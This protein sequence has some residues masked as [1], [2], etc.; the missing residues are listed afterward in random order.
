MRTLNEIRYRLFQLDG[1]KTVCK[2]GSL[3]FTNYLEEYLGLS[4]GYK[5]SDE[6]LDGLVEELARI[7]ALAESRGKQMLVLITPSKAGFI[8]KQI[9]DRFMKMERFYNE[10]DRAVHRLTARMEETGIPYLDSAPLLRGEQ[11]FDIFPKGG[12]HWTREASLQIVESMCK[13]LES[14][15]GIQ[16]KHVVVTGRRTQSVPWQ[17]SLIPDNDL[18]V[19]MNKFSSIK[20]QYSYPLEAEDI[21][22]N[23]TLPAVFVAGDSFSLAI[24]EILADHDMAK[25][26]NLLFYAQSLYDYDEAATTVE[27][28]FDPAI[29]QK[30][31]ESDII[32]LEV[33]EVNIT[34]MG[35]GFY[36]VLEEI[37]RKDVEPQKE[38]FQVQYR[39]FSPWETQNGV[40]HRWAYGKNA[41]LVYENVLPT[42]TLETTIWVPYDAYANL[43][44]FS[45]PVT[46]DAYVNGKKYQQFHCTENS[47]WKL[48]I[49]LKN[50]EV[51]Q[52]V[53]VE[54][55]SP[56]SFVGS[57]PTGEREICLQ[58]L[59]AG[60]DS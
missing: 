24:C 36:T 47:I 58:V 7:N 33:N 26:V 22:D 16:M 6:Y 34:Q 39:G 55:R 35:S 14:N 13:E 17:R 44:G 3:I 30:V 27:S 59:N 11:S 9:P 31:R 46:L 8:E 57:G 51:S 43:E 49:P 25:D 12:I 21:P 53:T 2:D 10:E 18:D 28:F 37:L 4:P 29:E 42:D 19:L 54:I 60:R 56:Y 5:G 40:T 38:P 52:D 41:L 1:D 20:T 15:G 45:G 32:I 50:I 23:Y 48:S